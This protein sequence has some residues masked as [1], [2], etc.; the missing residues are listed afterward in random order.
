L[1]AATLFSDPT[2]ART[3]ALAVLAA[4]PDY[5]FS[6]RTTFDYRDLSVIL[7]EAYFM[8]QDYE[9]A[10]VTIDAVAQAEGLPP[11]GLDPAQPETWVVEGVTYATYPAALA[12][13]I[14]NLSLL[15]AS[16]VPG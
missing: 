5:E 9:L 3:A 2:G 14:Q 4:D 10:Q 12:A 6:R 7:A 13:V 11:S 1:A 15:L 8:E 16:H